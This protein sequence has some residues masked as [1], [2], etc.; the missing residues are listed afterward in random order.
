MDY[1]VIM[2]AS[3]MLKKEVDGRRHIDGFNVFGPFH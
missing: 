3:I 1:A 2:S